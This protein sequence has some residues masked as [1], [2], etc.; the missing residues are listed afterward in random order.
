MKDAVIPAAT[1]ARVHYARLMAELGWADEKAPEARFLL[2]LVTDLEDHRSM[3]LAQ[4]HVARVQ[5]RVRPSAGRNAV[6]DIELLKSYADGI[7]IWDATSLLPAVYEL[8]RL[9]L[10]EP[11][12]GDHSSYAYQLTDA[13]RIVLA[14][15]ACVT[16][17]NGTGVKCTCDFA[18][19]N[20]M[21]RAAGLGR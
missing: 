12:G 21:L 7:R 20:Y 17:A 11:A 4:G 8:S 9:R 1:R 6:M 5:P 10:I 16:C 19:A 3:I 2:E 18:C 13:G 15:P 14:N